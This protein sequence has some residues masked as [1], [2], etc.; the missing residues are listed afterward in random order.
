MVGGVFILD[1]ECIVCRMRQ[2]LDM[3]KF[4]EADEALRQ[5]LMDRVMHILMRRDDYKEPGE[6]GLVLHETARKILNLDDP[7]L[8]VKQESIQKALDI[9]PKLQRWISE[10]NDPLLRA[11]EICIAGNVID[12]GPSN[13]HDIEL[14]LQ[15]IFSKPKNY[16]DWSEF[17]EELEKSETILM[18]ADNA[19]ETV[20]D[21]AFIESIRKPV[22]YA[23][24]SEAII[25]DATRDDALASGLDSAAMIMENGSPMS[26]TILPKCSPAFLHE[27]EHADMVISK[28]Q[29]NFET[30][31]EADRR[32]FFLFKVKC[33]LL[34]RH[35]NIPLNEYVLLDSRKLHEAA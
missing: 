1:S 23:V 21:R 18:L 30:L 35:N 7:Y 9:Y 12:F 31:V 28:G 15:E 8:I 25:N 16:F 22:I 33:G 4:V 11:V 26:G 32:I 20:F 24:K 13:Q 5:E 17:Q 10:A 3:C 34:S 29:A 19:G 6:I 27:F 2:A 14:A